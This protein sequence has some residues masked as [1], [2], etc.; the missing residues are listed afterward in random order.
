M[1][2]DWQEVFEGAPGVPEGQ[3]GTGVAKGGGGHEGVADRKLAGSA[4]SKGSL[5]CR[6][7]CRGDWFTLFTGEVGLGREVP[8]RG[9]M[10]AGS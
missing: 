8:V 7:A 3:G 9:G 2:G 10:G 4:L 1:V 5:A 6:G